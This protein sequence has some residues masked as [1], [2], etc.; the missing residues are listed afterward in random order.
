MPQFAV[1]TRTF[2]IL[3]PIEIKSDLKL[4]RRLNKNETREPFADRVYDA[5]KAYL[6][7]A[8]SAYAAMRRVERMARERNIELIIHRAIEVAEALAPGPGLL[9]N[10]SPLMPTKKPS[11]RK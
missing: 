8:P 4:T 9:G 10:G 1:I 11:P 2:R 5:A 6:V 3:N 7:E